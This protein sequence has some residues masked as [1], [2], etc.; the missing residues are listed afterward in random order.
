MRNPSENL[1][2]D[3]VVVCGGGS[4]T[5]PFQS[6]E[7]SEAVL[8]SVASMENTTKPCSSSVLTV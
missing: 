6:A 5:E 4:Q 7:L 2:N 1:Q 8:P 3:Y